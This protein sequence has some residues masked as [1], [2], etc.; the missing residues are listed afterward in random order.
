[1]AD[2]SAILADA[3]PEDRRG[4]DLAGNAVAVIVIALAA[5]RPWPPNSGRDRGRLLRPVPLSMVVSPTPWSHQ[6]RSVVPGPFA[7]QH[8]RSRRTRRS[9]ALRHIATGSS[10]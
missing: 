6:Y 1:M 9:A 3:L 8:P 5:P 4:L 2:S 10:F 7:L